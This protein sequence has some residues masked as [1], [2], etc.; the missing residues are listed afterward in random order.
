MD[1]TV[2]MMGYPPK[3]RPIER[4]SH[5]RPDPSKKSAFQECCEALEASA[6]RDR[7][8]GELIGSIN[9]PRHRNYFA[10]KMKIERGEK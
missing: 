1:T 4:I 3:G 10:N 9:D 5:V 8:R 2:M 6:E 7:E